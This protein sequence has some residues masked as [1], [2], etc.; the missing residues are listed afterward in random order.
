VRV[1][2]N[3]MQR[4]VRH[5]HRIAEDAKTP[6]SL[7]RTVR[8]QATLI[9]LLRYLCRRRRCGD[10]TGERLHP[11]VEP[12]RGLDRARAGRKNLLGI[13]RPWSD[14]ARLAV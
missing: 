8:D 2:V 9:R 3:F 14:E 5:V 11:E 7:F 12:R 6:I 1:L 13:R 4:D 10:R